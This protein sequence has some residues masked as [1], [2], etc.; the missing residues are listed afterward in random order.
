ML[1]VRIA[2]QDLSV[3]FPGILAHGAA[4]LAVSYCYKPVIAV[5]ASFF[6]QWCVSTHLPA[7]SAVQGERPAREF[8]GDA[9]TRERER[10]NWKTVRIL[11]RLQHYS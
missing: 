11:G 6:F 3:S 10:E 2:V 9:W 8:I 7:V 5:T 1:R 4:P